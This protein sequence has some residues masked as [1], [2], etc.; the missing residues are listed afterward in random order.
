MVLDTKHTYLAYRCPQCGFAIYGVAGQ[1]ALAADMIKIKC[2][3]GGSELVI[4][5]TSDRKLRLSVPCLFCGQNHNYVVSENVFFGQELFLLSC[6]YTNM[7]ICF[8]GAKEQV[9]KA[10][11]ESE[12]ELNKLFEE[13]N[14]ESIDELHS[15][16]DVDPDRIISDAQVYDI[17]RFLVKELEAD[18]AIDCPCHSG[19]YEFN[20]TDEGICVFCPI[21][22]AEHVF[23][24]DS[25][26]AAED[27]LKCDRLTLE[28]P[29]DTASD[30]SQNP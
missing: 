6:P 9:D 28:K 21:C 30:A 7:D 16:P 14:I 15:S 2:Q 29:A 23:P 20:M 11:G 26:S 12:T 22:G 19:Q 5:Y 10:V 1:F 13:M 4:N 25:L 8:I 18:G 3:C 27:F 24:A 17:V